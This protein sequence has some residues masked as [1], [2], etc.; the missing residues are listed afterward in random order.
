VGRE[1]SD[2]ARPAGALTDVAVLR[3]VARL[4]G[5]LKEDER[6]E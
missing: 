2:G 4:L 1:D 5:L 6:I 3:H